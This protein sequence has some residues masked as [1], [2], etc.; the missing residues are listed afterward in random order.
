MTAVAQ[1]PATRPPRELVERAL[2]K[3][4]RKGF[5]LVKLYTRGRPMTSGWSGLETAEAR[6]L[7]AAGLARIQE[8][9]EGSDR[10]LAVTLNGAGVLE[11]DVV[12]HKHAQKRGTR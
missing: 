8:L 11:R 4:T 9:C 3:F 5:R 6:A 12:A 2:A 7:E 1:T 10:R